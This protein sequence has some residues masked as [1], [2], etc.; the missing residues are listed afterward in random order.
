MEGAKS[1][2][3]PELGRTM[4]RMYSVSGCTPPPPPSLL[5]L[6][7]LPMQHPSSPPP[8]RPSLICSTNWCDKHPR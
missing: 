2:F 3:V 1:G 4:M 8:L 7:S 5:S 6:L